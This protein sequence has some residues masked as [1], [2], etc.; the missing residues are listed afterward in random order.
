[1]SQIY[2]EN[3]LYHAGVH[4][5]FETFGRENVLVLLFDDLEKNPNGVLARI[6]QHIGVDPSFFEE[7]KIS[8]QHNAYYVPKSRAV[9]WL[10][11]LKITRRVPLNWKVAVRPFLFSFEK[12][13]IDKE[14]RRRL[15]EFYGPDISRL[16]ELLG[17]KLPELRRSWT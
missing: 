10:Q 11:N 1:M 2:V 4:R 8:G 13:P 7:R 14:S 3:G 9:R 5:Y 16:E 17:R 15:Q 12:P 6:G